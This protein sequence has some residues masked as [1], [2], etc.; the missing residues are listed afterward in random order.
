MF[1]KGKDRL[2]LTSEDYIRPLC[3]CDIANNV[4]KYC[5]KHKAAPALYEAIRITLERID[6]YNYPVHFEYPFMRLKEAL[7]KAEESL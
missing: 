3:G 5:P 7:S 2:S 1:A 4:I 6:G